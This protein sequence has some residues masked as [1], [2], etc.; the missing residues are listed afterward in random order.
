MARKISEAAF[1]ELMR[2]RLITTEQVRDMLGLQTNV[3]V[4]H[5]VEHGWYTGPIIVRPRGFGL[6]DRV[7]VERQEAARLKDLAQA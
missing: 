6:W 7:A 3:G 5:R 4:M 1:A 2:E